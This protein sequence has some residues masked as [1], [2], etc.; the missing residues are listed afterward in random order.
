MFN[1]GEWRRKKI[2]VQW[3]NHLSSFSLF[4]FTTST[5]CHV[6]SVLLFF[7]L[8]HFKAHYLFFCLALALASPPYLPP[9]LPSS[10]PNLPLHLPLPHL[11][12]PRDM[13]S[14]VTH[15]KMRRRIENPR[16]LLLD[17]PLG[18]YVMCTSSHIRYRTHTYTCS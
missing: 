16:I 1:K 7:F 2:A 5:S 9:D 18:V 10:P 13:M 17:C 6:L 12:I 4:L 3:V 14:D 11:C 8:L 15:S